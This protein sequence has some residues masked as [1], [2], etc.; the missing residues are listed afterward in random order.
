VVLTITAIP[1]SIAFGTPAQVYTTV[2]ASG[3]A[4]TALRS[5]SEIAIFDGT[6]PTTQAFSDAA[7]TGAAAFAARRDHLHG[8]MAAPLSYEG[9]NT[10]EATTTSTSAVDLL[11]ASS[12][13]IAVTQPFLFYVNG[14]KTEGAG[15]DAALGLKLNATVVAEAVSANARP[16]SASV[17]N[18]AEQG[19]A[20]VTSGPRVTNYFS[21]IQGS[22]SNYF[23]QGTEADTS[24]GG[25][26]ADADIPDAELTDVVI[27]GITDNALQTIGADELHVYSLAVS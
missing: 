1:R 8:M 25:M 22:R 14:R 18:R 5:D 23:V 27:R 17:N 19:G 9:G 21:A 20:F 13:T 10:T 3:A 15:D 24:T 6:V 4:A 12:L 16:Y 7:A 26:A 2:D 11:T